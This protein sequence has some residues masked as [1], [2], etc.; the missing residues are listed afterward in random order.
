MSRKTATFSMSEETYD[1][2]KA[3]FPENTGSEANIIAMLD[4]LESEHADSEELKALRA[5]KSDHSRLAAEHTELQQAAQLQL[6]RNETRIAELK[7]ELEALQAKIAEYEGREPEVRE[8]EVEV[9]RP[10]AADEHVMH[11]PAQ[12][13]NLMRLT[14]E[15]LNNKY[16]TNDNID[17]LLTKMFLRYT[18]ERFTQWF[19]PWVLTDKDIEQQTGVTTSGWKQFLNGGKQ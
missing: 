6:E 16:N 17:D 9:E 7:S 15:R 14:V 13:Y 10:L 2:L 19:Y 18:V 3:H 1:R 11:I 8:V 12:I 5:I 4:A